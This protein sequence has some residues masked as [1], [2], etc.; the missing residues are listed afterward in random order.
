VRRIAQ[1]RGY[2]RIHGIAAPVGTPPGMTGITAAD[3]DLM[4]CI[5]RYIPYLTPLIRTQAA[6]AMSISTKRSD[7]PLSMRLPPEDLAVIDRAAMLRGR[8][9]T[10]FVRDVAV[11]AAEEVLLESTITR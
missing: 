9:R 5:P 10:D 3:P 4:Y 1:I 11:R 2:E 7:H 8:S 6:C